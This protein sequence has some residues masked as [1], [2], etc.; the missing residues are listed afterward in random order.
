MHARLTLCHRATS[1]LP[2]RDSFKCPSSRL[3]ASWFC[4]IKGRGHPAETGNV[5]GEA[6]IINSEGDGSGSGQKV[7]LEGEEHSSE[8]RKAGSKQTDLS[9]SG[10]LDRGTR[11]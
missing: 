3:G 11:V 4:S 10:A 1:L 6:C 2:Q 7:L 5:R 9:R 8:A